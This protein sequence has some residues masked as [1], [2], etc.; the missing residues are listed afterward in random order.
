M[1]GRFGRGRSAPG[2]SRVDLEEML[3]RA[4]R[5][6]T[7]ISIS[8]PEPERLANRLRYAIAAAKKRGHYYYHSLLTVR[9]PAGHAEEVWILKKRKVNGDAE[10]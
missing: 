1:R 2:P 6:D 9:I 8:T 4:L 5:S 7:G 3:S 10:S